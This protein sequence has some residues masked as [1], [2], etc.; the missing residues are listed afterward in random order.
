MLKTEKILSIFLWL[1]VLL[2]WQPQALAQDASVNGDA[3]KLIYTIDGKPVAFKS[4]LGFTHD[5]GGAVF[6]ELSTHPIV[7]SDIKGA[8]KDLK[9]DEER[10]TIR[11]APV[12]QPDGSSIWKASLSQF[13]MNLEW[14]GPVE[15]INLKTGQD[16][17]YTFNLNLPGSH[18]NITPPP[19]VKMQGDV[20]IHNCGN[21]SLNDDIFFNF[22]TDVTVT[23]AGEDVYLGGAT[24]RKEGSTY[25]LHLTSAMHG[26]G[27]SSIMSDFDIAFSL[28]PDLNEAIMFNVQG[29]RL[30]GRLSKLSSKSNKVKLDMS[31]RTE[32]GRIPID[33][34]IDVDM[35]G[36]PLIIKG[37]IEADQ[38]PDR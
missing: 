19:P 34:D 4:A 13:M 14:V 24:I 2:I 11:F 29:D 5:G 25:S 20:T 17:L 18:T 3:S 21:L 12:L 16:V 35:S 15:A 22:L 31:T 36:Y 30:A 10:L 23:L 33:V 9:R 38:C 8:S 37:R 6:L 32:G 1:A 7:C 28:T 27:Y 26:C